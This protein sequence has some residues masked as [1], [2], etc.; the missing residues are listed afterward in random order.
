MRLEGWAAGVVLVP[1]LRDALHGS[2]PQHEV[3]VG[4]SIGTRKPAQ[5]CAL[6]VAMAPLASASARSFSGWPLWPFTQ[7]HST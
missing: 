4:D 2:A 5:R 7:C 6:M 3:G 1:M